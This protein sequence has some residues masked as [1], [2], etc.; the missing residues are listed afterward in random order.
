MPN[1]DLQNKSFEVPDKLVALAKGN[2]SLS[3][4][5]IKKMKSE[6]DGKQNMTD[7]DIEL[8]K[9]IDKSLSSSR[10]AVELPK[11]IMKDTGGI[12]GKKGGNAYKD[13]H[14]KNKAKDP[15][16]VNDPVGLATSGREIV[17]DVVHS[18]GYEKEMSDMRYLIEYMNK[19]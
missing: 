3:Y 18:E 7:S 2:T 9:W 4:S 5:N 12:G 11:R 6:L 19:T 13:T 15:M 16:K 10:Q 14:N 8:L 17:N 1:Q